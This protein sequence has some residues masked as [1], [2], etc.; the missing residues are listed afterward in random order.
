[1]HYLY[2]FLEQLQDFES[3][4]K[5]ENLAQFVV[6]VKYSEGLTLNAAA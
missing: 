6:S 3:L 1:M 2:Q 4:W 5:Q